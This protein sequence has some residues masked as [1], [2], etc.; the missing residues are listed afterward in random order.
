MGVPPSKSIS[1]TGPLLL[2]GSGVAVK[3]GSR[4]LWKGTT[5]SSGSV[6]S[7]CISRST[8]LLYSGWETPSSGT[9]EG[10]L[11]TPM[12]AASRRASPPFWVSHS[13]RLSA[14]HHAHT[15]T[16][17]S[18]ASFLINPVSFCKTLPSFFSIVLYLFTI[19]PLRGADN[20]SIIKTKFHF[21]HRQTS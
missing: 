4:S 10:S 9:S 12:P 15:Q 8:A 2:S 21:I 19:F 1:S 5:P 18:I 16:L 7:L 20:F 17:I 6:P 13:P 3:P 14:A 11:S